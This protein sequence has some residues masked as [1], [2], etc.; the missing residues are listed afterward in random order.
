MYVK[1]GDSA[2]STD[3]FSQ[4]LISRTELEWMQKVFQ[5]DPP[6]ETAVSELL[7]RWS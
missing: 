1:S 3:A 6:V 4:E 2:A 5:G 7:C